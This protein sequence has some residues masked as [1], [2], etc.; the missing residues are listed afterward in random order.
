MAKFFVVVEGFFGVVL[1]S[2]RIRN[3][4]FGELDLI[5]FLVIFL[6]VL[7]LDVQ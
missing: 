2:S 3:F 7:I 4:F 6:F 5:F 1:G